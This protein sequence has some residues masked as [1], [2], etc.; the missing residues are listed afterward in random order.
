M[1]R[2]NQSYIE[3]K[4]KKKNSRIK[5]KVKIAS[6]GEKELLKKIE[7]IWE[8]TIGYFSFQVTTEGLRNQFRK[9][10]RITG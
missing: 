5:T 4:R 2:S 10:F 3:L 6:K 9:S 1:I 7:G 8:I